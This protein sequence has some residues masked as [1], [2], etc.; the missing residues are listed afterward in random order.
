MSRADSAWTVRRR[1]ITDDGVRI[2][3]LLRAQSRADSEGARVGLVVA[4]GFAASA[5]REPYRHVVER[6]SRRLPV[7]AFDFR[8]HGD[9]GGL[10]S[11]GDLEINDLDVAVR[12]ARTL[13]WRAVVTVGFSMGAGIVLRHAGVTGGVDG[14]VAVSGPAFWNYRGTP[15]MRRLHFGV[16][17]PVG[18]QFVRRA[19]RT[20]VIEPP[21]PTPWPTSP[22]EAA[23]LVPP[24]P[25]LVVHGSQDPFFPDE[26]PR[27]L[28]RSASAGAAQ[29]GLHDYRPELWLSEFGHAEAAISDDLLDRIAEWAANAAVEASSSQVGHG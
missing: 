9:S 17:H 23:S 8:G 19:M 10:C 16:E 22:S 2:Q 29:R 14:V 27:A 25:L 3:A 12:W 13:G 6:L 7:I 26:H 15:V 4:H 20:R 5:S 21:W 28:I 11:L 18:R 1:L 24:R